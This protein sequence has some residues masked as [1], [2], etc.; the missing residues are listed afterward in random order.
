MGCFGIG[1]GRTGAAAIEQN[2]DEK[3]IIWPLPIAPYHAVI[4]PLN[5]KSHAV[6]E[7]SARLAEELESIGMEVLVDDRPERPGVKFNDSDLIGF[8]FQVIVGD[9]GAAEGTVE[10]KNRRTGKTDKMPLRDARRFFSE[11]QSR[12]S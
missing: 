2:H 5:Q 9:K 11:I 6:A 1:I 8:P 7:A 12:W 4:L 3:G 10:I